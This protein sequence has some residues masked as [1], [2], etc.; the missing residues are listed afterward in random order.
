MRQP[1]DSELRALSPVEL[2]LPLT[3]AARTC[4]APLSVPA[5]SEAIDPI[6]IAFVTV[7]KRTNG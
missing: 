7:K 4:A 2:E 1:A 5:M 3:E 6:G